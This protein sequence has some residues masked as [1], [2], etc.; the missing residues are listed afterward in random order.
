ME[1]ICSALRVIGCRQ[2]STLVTFSK[3]GQQQ[4]DSTRLPHRDPSEIKELGTAALCTFEPHARARYVHAVHKPYV[5][6][7]PCGWT[8][9]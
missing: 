6:D 2:T 7:S 8:L 4:Q 3:L 1:G 5:Q 9:C